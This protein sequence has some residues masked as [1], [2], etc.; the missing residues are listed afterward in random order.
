MPYEINWEEHG[1]VVQFTGR[2]DFEVNK[3]ANCKVWEDSR[4]E[5]LKYAIW[6]ATGISESVMSKNDFNILAMQDHIGSSRLPKLKMALVAQGKDLRRLFEYYTNNYHSRLTG[7]DFMVS[8]S[9]ENIRN[10]ITS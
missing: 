8:D 9:M 10:W 1:V 3:N 4:C 5:S 7:W 6:D 2:F